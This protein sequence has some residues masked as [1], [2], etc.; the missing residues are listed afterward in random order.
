MQAGYTVYVFAGKRG[1]GCLSLTYPLC[2]VQ[3]DDN[4]RD[5]FGEGRS[6]VDVVQVGGPCGPVTVTW[7]EYPGLSNRMLRST[8]RR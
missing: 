5:V 4:S 6:G 3:A 7:V 8:W 2:T 1:Q